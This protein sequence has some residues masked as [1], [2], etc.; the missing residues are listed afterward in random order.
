MDS[1]NNVVEK[2][3]QR[4]NNTYDYSLVDY[5]NN[6]TKVKIICHK[7]R[8][9]EQIPN[10]HLNGSGCPYCGNENSSNNRRLSDENFILNAEKIHSNKYD[11]SLVEYKQNKII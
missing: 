9:F 6:K 3:K 7:H 8:M 11:Y 5:K 1:L 4:H 10:N 2:F